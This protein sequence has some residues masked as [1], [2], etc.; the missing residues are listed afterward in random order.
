MAIRAPARVDEDP[1]KQTSN[2]Q[3]MTDELVLKRAKN[4]DA[5][6]RSGSNENGIT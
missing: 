2:N 4:V 3:V 6:R 5:A 1:Q